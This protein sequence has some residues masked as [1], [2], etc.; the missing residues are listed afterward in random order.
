MFVSA[1]WYQRAKV[2]SLTGR[3]DRSANLGLETQI[4]GAQEAG[5]EHIVLDFTHV[6]WVD[7]AGLG[8]LFLAYHHLNR[9]K[10][11]LSIVNPRKEVL[12]LLELVAVPSLVSIYPTVAKA[13]ADMPPHDPVSSTPIG[14]EQLPLWTS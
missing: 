10:V 13:V 9:K 4:L 1:H 5:C 12:Q 11:K 2:I 3:L 8:K 6:S 14:N 7:S